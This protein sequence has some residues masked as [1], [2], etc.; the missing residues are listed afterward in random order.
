MICI[1]CKNEWDEMSQM[2]R[3]WRRSPSR[4]QVEGL[5]FFL[6]VQN[7]LK[8][9]M[10]KEHATFQESVCLFSDNTFNACYKLVG[11]SLTSKLV[12]K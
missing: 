4:V 5:T 3:F 2:H 1:L 7:E 10:T 6:P 11:N 8:V 12:C 9:A